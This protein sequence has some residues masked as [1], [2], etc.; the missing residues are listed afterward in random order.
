MNERTAAL[1]ELA[2]CWNAVG[3]Q[4]AFCLAKARHLIARDDITAAEVA[5]ALGVSRRTLFRMLEELNGVPQE[6]DTT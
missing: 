1:L 4:R 2:A 3:A 5:D 6:D